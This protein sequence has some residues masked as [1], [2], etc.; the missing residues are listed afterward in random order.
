MSRA[1]SSGLTVVFLL[2][3][4]CAAP[5]PR[6]PTVELEQRWQAH[7]ATLT[8]LSQWE[9]RGRLAVRVDERGG[10]ATLS[11]SREAGRH[12]IRLNGPFGSGAVRIVQDGAGARLQDAENRELAAGSAEELVWRY[13]GW[14]LPVAHLDWWLRGLPVPELNAQRELDETGRLRVLRQQGWEVQYQQYV[15]IDR[16]DLPQR[17]TLT[18]AADPATPAMEARF[19]IDRWQQVK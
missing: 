6:L 16:Y 3:V 12:Q 2:C 7:A 17:L 19:V 5:P 1:R 14:Q 10:Q 13:T 8:P 11:W 18:R 4:S 15:R 9:L